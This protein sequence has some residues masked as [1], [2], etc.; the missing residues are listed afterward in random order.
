MPQNNKFRETS[1]VVSV[2]VPE[3]MAE[4]YLKYIKKCVAYKYGKYIE[5]NNLRDEI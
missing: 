2:R 3:S 1:K 5:Q 4:E